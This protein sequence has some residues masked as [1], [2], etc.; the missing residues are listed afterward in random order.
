MLQYTVCEEINESSC[1]DDAIVSP[2]TSGPDIKDVGLWPAK[3]NDR[4]RI[5]LVR[6]GASAVRHLDSNF[7]ETYI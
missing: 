3:V 1:G 6:Q 7:D 2:G 5:I 4:T